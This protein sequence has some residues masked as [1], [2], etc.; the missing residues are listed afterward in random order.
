MPRMSNL[1]RARAIGLS[2]AGW[3]KRAIARRFGV[4]HVTILNL[5]RKF[6]ETG[7]VKDRPKSGRPKTTT[8]IEDQHIRLIA[9]RDRFSAAP[10]IRSTILQR[11]GLG[12]RPFSIQ[13][14]RNRLHRRGLR[15]R[16]AAKKPLLL[17]HHR[18]ARLEWANRHGRWSRAQWRDV[19]FTD[20][21]SF[22][23]NHSNGNV[24]V[25]R[26]QN[27]RYKDCCVKEV[28][29]GRG[30]SL[31]VWAGISDTSKTDLITIEGH[32]N[33]E[34]YIQ[35]VLEPVIVPR[36]ADHGDG[37]ILMDDNATPH[38]ARITQEYLEAEGVHRMQ[39]PA[40]SPDLN[41]IEHAWNYLGRAL[42]RRL[43][44]GERLQDIREILIEEWNNIP[45]Q[46]IQKLIRSMRRR[47]Q[48]VIDSQGGHT[49]NWHIDKERS[50]CNQ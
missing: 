22:C 7:D 42:S 25:W 32:I 23:V 45:Q 14:V 17:P 29:P 44:G 47:C 13:T 15:S 37:F 10:I 31:M 4:T 20:E 5:L 11:R 50:P 38:R 46:Y 43:R 48:A 16:I 30:G 39:W 27:E 19:L 35:E 26:R 33:A 24:R 9:L 36:A 3:T 2:E 41:P 18:R 6:E 34:Q 40:C 49:I 1:D 12:A 28:K 21:S 8:P